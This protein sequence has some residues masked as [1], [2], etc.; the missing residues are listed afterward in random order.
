[1]RNPE[2]LKSACLLDSL[3]SL[4]E[5]IAGIGWESVKECVE[6]DKGTFPD[7]AKVP[8]RPYQ[9][10]VFTN[11]SSTRSSPGKNARKQDSD[12]QL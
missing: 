5:I 9:N 12:R 1:M 3:K 6:L 4:T 11:H 8:R 7:F 2:I 10:H